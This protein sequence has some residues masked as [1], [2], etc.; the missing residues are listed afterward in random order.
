MASLFEPCVTRGVASESIAME[1]GVKSPGRIM[2]RFFAAAFMSLMLVSG[3][4]FALPTATQI[5]TAMQQGNW[6]QADAG[7]TQVL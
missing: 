5:E 2:K 7:L 6:Q 4:A 3:A 1:T